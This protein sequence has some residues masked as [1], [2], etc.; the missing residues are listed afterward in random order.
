VL[1]FESPTGEMMLR[2]RV[3]QALTDV[4]GLDWQDLVKPVA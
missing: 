4:A 1:A 3:I 2:S